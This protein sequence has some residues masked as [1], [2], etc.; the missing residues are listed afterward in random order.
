MCPAFVWVL[1]RV[2]LKEALT[3]CRLAAVVLS[4]GGVVIICAGKGMV[5]SDVSVVGV[6]LTLGAACAAALY[7]VCVLLAIC[8][9]LS[10]LLSLRSVRVGPGRI[11]S[12]CG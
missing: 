11:Q 3:V 2:F 5:L 6:L 12:A 10:Q 7:K 9:C 8:C 1:S 4:V